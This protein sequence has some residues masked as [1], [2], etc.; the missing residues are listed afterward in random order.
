MFLA[1]ALVAARPWQPRGEA[2]LATLATPRGVTLVEQRAL[3]REVADRLG[4]RRAAYLGPSEIPFLLGVSNPVP[5]TIWH[6]SAHAFYARPGEAS[7]DTLSRMLHDA[8]V[9][10][11]VTDHGVPPARDGV[12]AFQETIGDPSRCAVDVWHVP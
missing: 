12:F 10:L 2:A 4:G 7:F 1:L 5:F 3:A 9:E 6:A 11:V 8:G